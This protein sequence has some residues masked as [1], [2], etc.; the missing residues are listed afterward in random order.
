V[1]PAGATLLPANCTNSN[2]P[3]VHRFHCSQT[4][5]S[6]FHCAGVAADRGS[7]HMRGL[8]LRHGTMTTNP[9]SQ[10][11]HGML[12]SSKAADPAEDESK[13]AGSSSCR[14]SCPGRIG[15]ATGWVSTRTSSLV[16]IHSV[17]GHGKAYAEPPI[18]S[19]CGRASLTMLVAPD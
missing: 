12:R 2:A 17:T 10:L 8:H 13:A 5:L 3:L 19:T 1:G 7:L 15:G 9:I 14:S 4:A 18:P 11:V 16:Y 6:L